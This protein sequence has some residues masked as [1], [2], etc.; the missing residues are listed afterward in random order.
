MTDL[1]CIMRNLLKEKH[2]EEI[3]KTRKNLLNTDEKNMGNTIKIIVADGKSS[4]YIRASIEVIEN[5]LYATSFFSDKDAQPKLVAKRFFPN[6]LI[7][8][9]KNGDDLNICS[10]SSDPI[11]ILGRIDVFISLVDIH[12]M[13]TFNVVETLSL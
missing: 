2:W 8:K 5:V 1:R 3:L 4:Y 10:V 7:K 9:M 11:I 6:L 12:C 13:E